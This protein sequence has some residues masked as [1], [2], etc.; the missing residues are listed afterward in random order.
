MADKDIIKKIIRDYFNTDILLKVVIVTRRKNA[1]VVTILDS[2]APKEWEMY[3]PN[4]VDL[5][6]DMA[7]NLLELRREVKAKQLFRITMRILK[8]KE[9]QSEWD[10]MWKGTPPEENESQHWELMD[11]CIGALYFLDVITPYEY[12]VSQ[13]LFDEHMIGLGF[14]KLPKEKE[15]VFGDVNEDETK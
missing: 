10:E 8:Y 4:N 15:S 14:K 9:K 1:E 12:E 6:F 11:Y 7:N 5:D 3:K 13:P 2:P